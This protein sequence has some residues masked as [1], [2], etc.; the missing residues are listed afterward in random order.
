MY[1]MGSRRWALLV[2][3]LSAYAG[4]VQY[5]LSSWDRA[6][7]EQPA[8]SP[9]EPVR[10][11]RGG[12]AADGTPLLSGPPSPLNGKEVEATP[13]ALKFSDIGDMFSFG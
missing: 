4:A 1:G 7:Q 11:D 8:S 13:A 10:G 12:V 9:A 6:A 5:R 2:P 3:R